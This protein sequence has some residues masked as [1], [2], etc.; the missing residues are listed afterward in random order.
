M[1]GGKQM[2]D[3]LGLGSS[4]ES[5]YRHVL[6]NSGQDAAEIGI[7]LGLSDREVN[8]ALDLLRELQLIRPSA[9]DP[10]QI[11]PVDPCLGMEILLSRQRI[12]QQM[13]TESS[14]LAAAEFAAEFAAPHFSAAGQGVQRL[15]GQDQIRDHISGLAAD[16]KE[17][18]LTFAHSGPQAMATMEALEP[19][20]RRLL[21][22][23]VRLMS[24][25]PDSV[26]HSAHAMAQARSLLSLGVE[27][28]TANSLPTHLILCDRGTALVASDVFAPVVDA[29]VVTDQ[30]ILSALGAL[31][32]H[33]WSAAEPLG[34]DEAQDGDS[35]SRQQIRVLRLL[36]QGC[37]DE[38]VA[39]RL[40][41]ST[42]TARRVAADVMTHLNARSRLQAGVHAVQRG[43]L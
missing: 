43:Y 29:V 26:W 15:H 25:Y 28:R 13:R 35:L 2:L 16:A 6:H 33:V 23:G 31:F 34:A 14:R 8:D 18:I 24:V 7:Q 40:G 3:I 11:H 42:R 1:H 27:V 38:A 30:G 10:T 19:L 41:I 22:R 37:T 21:E 12:T 4:A 32:D 17:E 9:D 39:R 36:A 5:V 20:N